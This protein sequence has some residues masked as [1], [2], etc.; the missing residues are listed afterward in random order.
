MMM[1]MMIISM[2][3]VDDFLLPHCGFS[4]SSIILNVISL[5]SPPFLYTFP[6]LTKPYNIIPYDL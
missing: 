3:M 2:K 6:Q 1:A 4:F 5:I